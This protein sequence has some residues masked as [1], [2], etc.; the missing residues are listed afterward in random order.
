MHVANADDEGGRSFRRYAL[1]IALYALDMIQDG[2]A[3]P[4][5]INIATR[6]GLR[7]KVGLVEL[8]D[9]LIAEF[10]IDGVLQLV[11]RAADENAD[12]PHMVGM[13]DTDGKTGPRAGKPCLLHE[14]K[15][16]NIDRL[17]GYGRSYHTPVAELDL[18][19]GVRIAGA[20][21]I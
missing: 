3:T 13:L 19:S 8:I 11:R 5:Q 18:R 6:A 9:A 15:S 16:R 12:D 7:F 20:I 4:G 1:P 10:T 2:F 17:L 14:M 21:S